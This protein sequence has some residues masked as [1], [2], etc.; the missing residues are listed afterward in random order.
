MSEALKLRLLANEIERLERM[1]SYF[2]DAIGDDI[3]SVQPKVAWSFASVCTGY[4]EL[5]HGVSE[6]VDQNFR[7]I[8]EAA[9]QKQRDRVAAARVEFAGG[10]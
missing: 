1:E 3:R 6:Y 5:A 8:C 4:N 7:L 2:A 10:A 9:I